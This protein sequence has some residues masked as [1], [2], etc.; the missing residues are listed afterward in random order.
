MIDL[1]KFSHLK[2]NQTAINGLQF[3][4]FR[5]YHLF[6]EFTLKQDYE[7]T[8]HAHTKTIVLRMGKSITPETTP[9]DLTEHAMLNEME[10]EDWPNFDL[11]DGIAD[12]IHRVM[13]HLELTELGWVT[14]ATLAPDCPISEHK[15]EGE[16]CKNF[17]R[18]HVCL[19]CDDPTPNIINVN[20][21]NY[22][23]FEGDVF[24]FDN[25][26]THSAINCSKTKER[27]HL[28]FDAR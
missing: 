2:L 6:D 23:I 26:S 16:Y 24:T 14:I 3:E 7:G 28:I 9:S 4:I 13:N 1:I 10:F 15:D 8:A 5:N 20:T 12:V 21:N 27:I 11:F 19:Y 22:V 25:K 17:H 18:F